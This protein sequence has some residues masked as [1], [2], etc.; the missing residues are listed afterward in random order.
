MSSLVLTVTTGHHCITK[1]TPSDL[2]IHTLR[3]IC[4]HRG[5]I[6]HNS[7]SFVKQIAADMGFAPKSVK[8]PDRFLPRLQL[9]VY[10]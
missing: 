1:P 3:C 4:D 10:R 9:W 7:H 5:E 8:K 6:Y 2:F